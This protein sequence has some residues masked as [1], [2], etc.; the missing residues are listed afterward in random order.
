[1]H[2]NLTRVCNQARRWVEGMLSSLKYVSSVQR[3]RERLTRPAK[4]VFISI[5][6]KIEPLDSR[7][8]SARVDRTRPQR[9]VAPARQHQKAWPDA[10]LEMTRRATPDVRLE[11][12]KG[13]ESDFVDRTRESPSLILVINDTKLIMSCVKW[14]KL[15]IRN[16]CDEGACGMKWWPQDHKRWRCT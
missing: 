2:L 1:M 6:K 10:K 16:T 4:R 13:P 11:S 14:F 9:P 5:P 15:G 8:C 7:C 12:S 3:V